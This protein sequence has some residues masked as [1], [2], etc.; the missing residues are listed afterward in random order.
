[1]QWVIALG[2]LKLRPQKA[3]TTHWF[4]DTWLRV[5]PVKSLPW[6]HDF[7]LLCTQSWSFVLHCRVGISPQLGTLPA[8]LGCWGWLSAFLS[9]HPHP[10]RV[11][12]AGGEH[13]EPGGPVSVHMRAKLVRIK[14]NSEWALSCS[15]AA[16]EERVEAQPELQ[17]QCGPAQGTERDSSI[18]DP[19]IQ[20]FFPKCHLKRVVVM[21]SHYQPFACTITTGKKIKK[22]I[23][24]S[25]E[26]S[27][28][29][30]FCLELII[31]RHSQSR[32]LLIRGSICNHRKWL[33]GENPWIFFFIT[34][35]L[36]VSL[37]SL[38]LLG[39]LVS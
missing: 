12:M 23:P 34:E 29:W 1:M 36:E 5:V 37:F 4:E 26:S 7:A 27:L 30:V 8:G 20:S 19:Q 39:S 16:R 35:F 9:P 25:M 28:L 18:L 2:G 10:W 14:I 24:G 3:L 38:S 21:L 32:V 15:D 13:E 22:S 6:E 33:A 17:G 31:N 11:F